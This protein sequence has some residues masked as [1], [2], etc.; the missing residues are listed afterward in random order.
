MLKMLDENKQIADRFPIKEFQISRRN[1]VILRAYEEAVGIYKGLDRG[2]FELVV[3]FDNFKVIFPSESMEADVLEKELNDD[4]IGQKI[5]ILRTD[6][7]ER[8]LLVSVPK[9]RLG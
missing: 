9:M 8:P 5:T 3:L 7:P 2:E 6:I 1:R 4:L